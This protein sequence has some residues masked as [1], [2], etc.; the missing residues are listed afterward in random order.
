MR[1]RASIVMATR[2]RAPQLA[3][4]LESIEA[5]G[6]ENVEVVVVDDGSDDATPEVLAA[7]PWVISERLERTGAYKP[8]PGALYNLAHSLALSLIHISEPTRPY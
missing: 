7:R 4:A 5:Q 3:A 6:Y 2:N 1:P 8:N